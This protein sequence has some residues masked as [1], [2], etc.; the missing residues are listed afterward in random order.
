MLWMLSVTASACW[1]MDA[2]APAAWVTPATTVVPPHFELVLEGTGPS[3]PERVQLVDAATGTPVAAQ[4]ERVGDSPRYALLVRPSVPA[5]PG[6]RYT[7]HVD[8]PSGEPV[9]PLADRTFQVGSPTLPRPRPPQLLHVHHHGSALGE[10]YDQVEPLRV[11]SSC[12][13]DLAIELALQPPRDAAVLELQASHDPAFD[14]YRTTFS[15]V[16]PLVQVGDAPCQS[17]NLRLERGRR[18]WFRVRGRG[19]DGQTSPWSEVGSLE[20]GNLDSDWP[21]DPPPA[22]DTDLVADLTEAGWRFGASAAGVLV[23]L[24][25]W[26]LW[27]RRRATRT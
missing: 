12:G 22:P 9:Q 19:L 23:A 25:G 7:L 15:P 1:C 18:T 24:L 13:P 11:L 14:T 21:P 3:T 26:G 2:E 5:E 27:R 10:F 6:T 4:V 8:T 16:V 17:P 20:V